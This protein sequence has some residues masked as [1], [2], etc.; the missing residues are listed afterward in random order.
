MKIRIS[1]ARTIKYREDVL[2]SL[3]DEY[4]ESYL[5]DA[6]FCFEDDLVDHPSDLVGREGIVESNGTF[7]FTDEEVVTER[8]H[9]DAEPVGEDGL[10]VFVPEHGLLVPADECLM[11]KPEVEFA[12]SKMTRDEFYDEV[13]NRTIT[14]GQTGSGTKHY[15]T[16]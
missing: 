4:G 7:I 6:F 14:I 15:L 16:D 9:I 13:N 2:M 11:F 8:H 3:M 5:V 1:E 12:K 10:Y